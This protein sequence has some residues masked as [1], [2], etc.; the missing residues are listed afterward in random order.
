MFKKLSDSVHCLA[1]ALEDLE[2][3]LNG[4]HSARE[5]RE[6]IHWFI[7]TI[8]FSVQSSQRRLESYTQKIHFARAELG[9]IGP[10]SFLKGPSAAR[11]VLSRPGP[12]IS[13][14]VSAFLF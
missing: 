11:L 14:I 6:L 4:K 3:L 2:K 13:S 12:K 10:Q 5:K 8:S 9:I 1:F 7:E